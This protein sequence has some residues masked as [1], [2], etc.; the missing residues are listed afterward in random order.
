M[1]FYSANVDV[2]LLVKQETTVQERVKQ[3]IIQCWI[4]RFSLQRPDRMPVPPCSKPPVASGSP[5]SPSARWAG[6]RRSL[7]RQV[8]QDVTC[9]R[10]GWMQ[11]WPAGRAD[12]RWRNSRRSWARQSA[13]P[14]GQ[15]GE[16]CR[17]PVDA[18]G[19]YWWNTPRRS[20]RWERPA[21]NWV[22]ARWCTP[23]YTTAH[24]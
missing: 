21:G 6:N 23:G 10:P 8:G 17:P 14:D 1:P 5:R 16:P 20:P 12:T 2:S 19:F 18:A 9:D 7:G 13:W 24:E 22:W 4:R 15:S 11:R 3:F